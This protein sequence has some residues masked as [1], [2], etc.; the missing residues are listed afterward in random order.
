MMPLSLVTSAS[1]RKIVNILDPRYTLPSRKHNVI[2]D[3]G[4]NMLKAF[5][6]PGFSTE[7]ESDDEDELEAVDLNHDLQLLT[8]HDPCFAHSLQLVVKDGFKDTAS[9]NK[10]LSKAA[11][12]MVSHVRW[13]LHATEVLEGEKRLQTK[14][15]TRW[16]SELKSVRSL[17]PVPEAK[18]QLVP[19]C[20]QLSAYE[21]NIL[22]KLI[23]ILTPF[24]EATDFAQGQNSVTVSFVIPCICGLRS[25]LA[26]TP[27]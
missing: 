1:F 8:E 12:N 26:S 16:N 4:S 7:P 6:L 22:E 23:A 9:S 17:L 5:R 2:T 24:G 13:S 3:N 15:A 14:V 21:G 11:N 27:V 18:L 25:S 10:V 20:Q 19:T